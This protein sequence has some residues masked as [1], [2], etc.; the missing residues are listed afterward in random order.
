[1]FVR[2]IFILTYIFFCFYLALFL[3]FEFIKTII[4]IRVK[5]LNGYFPDGIAELY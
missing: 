3:Q 4:I 2:F 5:Y 1:M